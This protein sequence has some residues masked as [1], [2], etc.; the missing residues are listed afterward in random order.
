MA[1]EGLLPVPE[2]DDRE[3]LKR[4][5]RDGDRNA[6]DEL[7]RRSIPLARRLARRYGRDGDS[8]E[9]LTQVAMVGLLGAIER[10]DPD[11][12]TS[13]NS[14]AIPTMLGELKRYFRDHTW[15]V[16][17]PRGLQEAAL[18]VDRA[19]TRLSGTLGR[20]PTAQDVADAT[21]MSVEDV[22][23]AMQ[24]SGAHER[25]SLDARL[26]DDDD[27]PQRIDSLG[28]VDRGYELV[29][30][31]AMIQPEWRKL[32]LRDRRILLLRFARDRTQSEIAKELGISQMH[33]SRLIRRAL[34]QLRQASAPEPAAD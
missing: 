28:Q 31:E 32:P 6:K 14:Y 5:A 27:S 11:R 12:G 23:D 2:V 18:G 26:S 4:I 7:V 21:G 25:V 30:D 17:V 1:T 16:H 33:V 13:F 24:A 8:L 10:Y 19:V 20:S 29:D 9:D 34:E 15:A 22:L 3:L